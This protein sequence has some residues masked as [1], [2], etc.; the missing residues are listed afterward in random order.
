MKLNM[1]HGLLNKYHL[2]RFEEVIQR[3]LKDTSRVMAFRL[4]LRLPDGALDI[5]KDSAV[6]TRFFASLRAQIKAHELR[7]KKR[8]IR[9]YPCN[10]QYLWV[11]EFGLEKNKKHYHLLILV[12]KDAYYSP[13]DIS[14]KLDTK[15]GVL[16]LMAIKA[17][18]RALK[19]S[20]ESYRSLVYLP[21]AYY[22]LKKQ[23]GLN[24]Q[25]YR[26]LIYHTSYMAKLATKSS[27]DGERNFGCSQK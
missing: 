21:S 19:L 12:N 25:V 11:R 20:D 24:S 1:N 13:G 5:D 22:H 7:N 3:T 26:D 17:W 10:L 8:G 23:E 27:E 14:G 15:R 6:I 16:T 18:L 4:D 9:V 2:N